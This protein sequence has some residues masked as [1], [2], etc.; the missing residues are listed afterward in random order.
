MIPFYREIK[1][2]HGI[3]TTDLVGRMLLLT[4]DH[5]QRGA[6]EYSIGKEGQFTMHKSVCFLM[7]VRRNVFIWRN[8]LLQ[9]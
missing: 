1:R 7:Y 5:F 9:I 3:S 4:K 8:I 6:T 2:T